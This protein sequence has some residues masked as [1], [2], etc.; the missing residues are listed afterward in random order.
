MHLILI[1]MF[2][3]HFEFVF[4]LRLEL[5]AHYDLSCMLALG[6]ELYV[7]VMLEFYVCVTLF[8]ICLPY[9]LSFMSAL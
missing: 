9:A 6:F 4:A 7:C 5:C 1:S 2:S 8:D 3:I